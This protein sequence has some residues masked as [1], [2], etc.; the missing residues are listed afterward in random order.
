MIKN[1]FYLC[2]NILTHIMY[3]NIMG[4]HK[5]PCY[6]GLEIKLRI[7]IFPSPVS[8]NESRT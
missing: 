3:Y 8:I 1:I 4:Y 7:F 6:R 5:N 2:T